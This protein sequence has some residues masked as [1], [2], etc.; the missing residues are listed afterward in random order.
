MPERSKV[1]NDKSERIHCTVSTFTSVNYYIFDFS[2]MF[3]ITFLIIIFLQIFFKIC[4][5]RLV[6]SWTGFFHK[7]HVFYQRIAFKCKMK[8]YRIN[9]IM[10]HCGERDSFWISTQSWDRKVWICGK[11]LVQLKTIGTVFGILWTCWF[12]QGW[13]FHNLQHFAEKSKIVTFFMRLISK[14]VNYEGLKS[15]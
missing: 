5:V 3:F 6:L 14:H 9:S 7:F 2:T 8:H 15:S 12:W 4:T 11:V 13:S 1:I 10:F